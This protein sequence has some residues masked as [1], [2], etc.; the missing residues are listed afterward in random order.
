MDQAAQARTPLWRRGSPA[1]SFLSMPEPEPALVGEPAHE[2]RVVRDPAGTE[3]S[4]R[5]LTA[6]A[7]EGAPAEAFFSL[8]T[9]SALTAWA[10]CLE[11]D[12][13][14]LSVLQSL[15]V[16]AQVLHGVAASVSAQKPQRRV[17]TVAVL[18]SRLA[19]AP[20]I[21]LP[22]LD[23]GHDAALAL[24][25]VVSLVSAVA[26][27]FVQ[28][29]VGSWLGGIVPAGMR[30]RFFAG[31]SRIATAAMA[32]GALAAA[33]LLDRESDPNR[34][35]PAL[36]VLATLA[37]AVGLASAWLMH[38][39]PAP[40]THEEGALPRASLLATA[41]DPR[42]RPLLV[43]QLLLGAAISPGTAFFSLWLLD[44]LALPYLALAGHAFVIALARAL[45]APL[46]GRAVDRFGARPVLVVSTLGVSAMPLLW[47]ASSPDFV[48]PL[49]LDAIISGAL[50][51][52]QQIAM[53]DLPLRASDARARPQ[54]LAAVAM[55]LGLGWIGGSWL[56]GA[57]ASGL[58][59]HGTFDEPLRVIFVMSALGRAACALLALR[60]TDDRAK[61]VGSLVRHVAL[62]VL[63][64]S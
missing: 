39:M 34:D 58:S 32:L 62:R 7:L 16:G 4:D 45:A 60:V 31:R 19:W 15:L 54:A 6:A 51:G 55:A 37:C 21:A 12:A 5:A 26:H 43:Y 18:V 25:L 3:P 41:R 17:A 50:W 38:R 63:P 1:R 23:V 42:L 2:R 20:M 14:Y 53:F 44:R 28:N 13:L 59:A 56:F 46:W 47:M 61:T 52:G 11:A 36:A 35:G 64:T 40:V 9:G 49:V 27:V 10:L 48:W 8:A 30:G 57:L 24:L 22:F 29:A 33:L